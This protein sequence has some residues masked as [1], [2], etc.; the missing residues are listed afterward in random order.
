MF[1]SVNE[2]FQ[3]LE[4][5]TKKY[6]PSAK[7][8][9]NEF[10]VLRLKVRLMINISLF[11]DVFYSHRKRWERYTFPV[12]GPRFNGGENI[13]MVSIGLG[14]TRLSI[15][16]L[17]TGHQPIHNEDKTIWVV[18][19]GEIYNFK[20]LSSK[21]K[22]QGHLFYTRSDTEVIVHLYEE[23]G[24]EFVQHLNGMYAIALWDERKGLLMLVR[25]RLGIKPLYYFIGTDRLVFASEIKAILE[26]KVEKDIDLQALSDYLAY[27]YIPAPRSIFKGIKKLLPGHMLI[28]EV[29]DKVEVKVRKY[30][31]IEFEK[32]ENGK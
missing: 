6:L 23:Y 14:Q 12:Q 21:L 17:T 29:K 28:C 8:E 26:D 19:N 20:A 22:D 30:W 4:R 10:N 9:I 31:D 2:F 16:D 25:D 5:S 11:I 24:E 13:N 32:I 7:L 15:I 1:N 3:E 27:N 18:L